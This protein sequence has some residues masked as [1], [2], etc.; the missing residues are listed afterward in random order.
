[1]EGEFKESF[2]EDDEFDSEV[3]GLELDDQL[4]A[5]YIQFYFI[6]FFI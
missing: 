3:D 1:M 5:F 4:S 6:I 2:E